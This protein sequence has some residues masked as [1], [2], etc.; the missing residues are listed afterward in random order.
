[1]KVSGST[2]ITGSLNVLGSVTSTGTL[3]AQTLVVQTITSS[4]LYSSGS[5]IF[6]NSLGNT[7]AMTGSVGITGSLSLNNIAIP[8]SA[9]LASTYLP[10]TGGTLTGTSASTVLSLANSTGGTKADFTIT[11]NTGLIIN[12]YE[13]AS[14][15]SINLQV[16][17]T[18]ALL[19]ASTGAATFSS[20]VQATGVSINVGLTSDRLFYLSGN[21]TTTG[22]SQFQSVMNG[23]VVNAATNIYGSYIGNNSNVTTT[24]SYAI[25]LET[26]GGS[27]TIT[28]KYG[29]YQAGSNDK[30]YFAGATTFNST[31]TTSGVIAGDSKFYNSVQLTPSLGGTT[32]GFMWL[33]AAS[34]LDFGVGTVGAG[35]I[36]MS[37]NS[38]GLGIGTTPLSTLHLSSAANSRVMYMSGAGTGY[39][40]VS[41]YSTGGYLLFGIDTSVG[42]SLSTGAPAYASVIT[43]ANNT[44][45]SFGINQVEKFRIETTGTVQPGANGT[46]DLGTSSLRWA[47]V[48]TSDLSLSNGIGDY[49]IVEGEDDL[50]LYNNKSNKVYKFMLAEVDPANATPKKST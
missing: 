36:K 42:G 37:L 26:T 35:N 2:T 48:Y 14:A 34:R 29:I 9:S 31:I 28:N 5:N 24:N 1:M 44:A 47:T 21:L 43:T 12:S 15:R 46:Q 30:N 45:L 41:M 19:L 18:S 3:T 25:Y 33:G 20:T 4:V 50:F 10:L 17:G 6:G 7:Q 49:T 23:T 27:G 16:A 38:T 40:Y 39:Q 22:T 11:E 8:T 32:E 13:G